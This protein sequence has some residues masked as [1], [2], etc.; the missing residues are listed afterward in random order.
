MD[1]DNSFSGI[2]RRKYPRVN[3]N[4]NYS[5]EDVV[6]SEKMESTKN[7]SAGGIAFFAREQVKVGSV[8]VLEMD[9]PDMSIVKTKA[10]VVWREP[11]KIPEDSSICCELGVEF[12]EVDDAVRKKISKYVFLRLDIN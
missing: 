12:L 10:R 8:L 7:I 2:D 3:A 6:L 4:V 9:L 11:I 5:V 1:T